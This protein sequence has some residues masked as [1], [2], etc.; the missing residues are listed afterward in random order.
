MLVTIGPS[1]GRREGAKGG[2]EMQGYFYREA[3][4]RTSGKKYSTADVTDRETHLTNDAVQAR[5]Q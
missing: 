2:R 1:R 5:L 3:Y 4:V